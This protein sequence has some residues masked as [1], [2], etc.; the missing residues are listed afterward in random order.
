MQ[1]SVNSGGSVADTSKTNRKK[2]KRKPKDVGNDSPQAANAEFVADLYGNNVITKQAAS[3]REGD[4]WL[5]RHGCP[6]GRRCTIRALQGWM[7]E[8]IRQLGD[9]LPRCLAVCEP[10]GPPAPSIHLLPPCSAFSE[11]IQANRLRSGARGCRP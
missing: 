7:V 3:R 1:S 2:K 5:R 6:Q 10:R 4:V 11:H 9:I 8:V